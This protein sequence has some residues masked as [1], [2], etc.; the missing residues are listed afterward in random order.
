M[1][2]RWM[3]FFTFLFIISS[4]SR[5]TYWSDHPEGIAYGDYQTY[6]I[7]E[8]CSD[9]DPGVNPINQLRIKNALE[10]ELRSMGMMPSEDPDINVKFFIKNETKYFYENCIE[11]Y[12]Q[13]TG[14]GQCVDKVHSYL[15]GTLVIDFID[16]RRNMAVWHAGARGESWDSI[17]NPDPV[18]KRMVKDLMM[19]YLN[20]VKAESF[21]AG[22]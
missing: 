22:Q 1:I 14:G 13:F 5:I 10:I 6:Q 7:D 2:H 3:F 8:Q 18:I 19:E 9:Y 4:C 20:L 21:A 16:V 12:D 17:D 15:E 11:E